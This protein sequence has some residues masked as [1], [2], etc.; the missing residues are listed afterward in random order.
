MSFDTIFEPQKHVSDVFD[1][2]FDTR[3]LLQGAINIFKMG[4]HA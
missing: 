3:D 4:S 2:H 1:N